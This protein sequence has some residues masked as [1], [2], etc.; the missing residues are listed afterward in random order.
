MLRFAAALL[1][2]AGPLGP[3]AQERPSEDELFGSPPATPAQEPAE[4]GHPSVEERLFGERPAEAAPRPAG[5][6]TGEKEDPLRLGGQL[7]L[8]GASTWQD[9][10]DP[11]D[12]SVSSPNLLD[13]YLDVR[14]NDRVR[15]FALGRL[16]YDPTLE[17]EPED[18]RAAELAELLGGAAPS[19]PDAVLDQLWVNFDLGRSVFVTAGKQHVKWGVGRLWNPTDYLH[20]Q[21]RDPLDP[22][23]ARTGTA[24]VKLHAPWEARGWNAYGIVLLEDTAARPVATG[25]LGRIGAGARAEVVLG[26]FELGLDGLVADGHKPRFGVDVSLGLWELDLHAEAALRTGSSVER[27]RRVAGSPEPLEL[28]RLRYAGLTPQIVVGGSWSRNYTDE[29]VFTV[30]AEYFY[31]DTG[32]DDAR[33]YPYLLA[34]PVLHAGEPSPFSSFYLGKHQAGLFVTLPAPGS[35]NDTTLTASVLGNLSDGSF[36]VRLDHSVLALTYLRVETYVA[37]H[38]GTRGGAYRFALDVDPSDFAGTPIPVSERIVVPPAVLDLGVA[39][40]VDL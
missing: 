29:D 36:V 4:P 17:G 5:V 8:R 11:A 32:Y 24:M 28:E 37:G 2:A 14:P 12:W 23:D 6:V 22:F 20:R 26:T 27:W 10:I 31:D 13:L 34:V 21:A 39:L 3:G 16:L 33:I 1:L 18:P 9:G 38:L 25:R 7:Y 19:N 40:R 35:W 15:A 30:G